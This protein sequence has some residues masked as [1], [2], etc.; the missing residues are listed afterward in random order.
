MPSR[1]ISK[2]T[3]QRLPTYLSYLRSR[4]E[5]ASSTFRR[6]LSQT[7]FGMNQVVVRKD[8][9]SISTSGRPKV[10]YVRQDLILELERFLGYDNAMTLFW[11]GQ[12]NWERHCSV[13]MAFCSMASTF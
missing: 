5:D 12:V 3:L 8:L 6:R 13:S 4:G 9:A 7:L 10:G 1:C 11:S 2:Q